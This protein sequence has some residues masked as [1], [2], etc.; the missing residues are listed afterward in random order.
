[1]D[2]RRIS[3]RQSLALALAALVASF[4]LGCASEDEPTEP[5]CD[6]RCEDSIAL[7]GLRETVKLVYNLTLQGKPVGEQDARTD[8]P[9]GG[10]ARVFGSATSNPVHGATEVDLTYEL[11]ACVYL[12]LDEDPRETY[13]LGFLGTLTQVG[14]LAVQPTAPTALIMKSDSLSLAGSVY[15]PPREYVAAECGVELGQSGNDLSGIFC[16][17]NVGVDLGGQP[18]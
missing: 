15:D 1:M 18:N 6:T 2:E 7:L 17:R 12:E 14:T 5:P 16:G 10:S 13:Q 3:M 11:D 4:A 9:Q 8:C